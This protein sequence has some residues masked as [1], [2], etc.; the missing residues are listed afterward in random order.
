MAGIKGINL[1][2]GMSHSRPWVIWTDM[3]RRCKNPDRSSFEFYGGKGISYQDSWEK[4]EGFWQ[5]MEQGY[6]D[7]LTLERIDPS[8][9]YCK[10]NC[11]WATK[12]EQPRNKKKYKNNNTGVEGT[13]IMMNKGVETLKAHISDNGKRYTKNFSLNKYSLEE[14]LALA[15]EW[16]IFMKEK[17]N[18]SAFHGMDQ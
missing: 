2:H 16:R 5:D 9:N 6:G 12:Q 14:A 15:K 3:K 11:R 18:Y 8:G 13:Y 10:E 7:E 4:F 1:K 17:L